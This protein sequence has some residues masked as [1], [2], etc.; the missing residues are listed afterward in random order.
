MDNERTELD[1]LQIENLQLRLASDVQDLIIAQVSQIF[2]KRGVADW[3]VDQTEQLKTQLAKIYIQLQCQLEMTQHDIMN[4]SEYLKV[5][6][7]ET[8]LWP[9]HTNVE[10]LL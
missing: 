9:G 10:S 2:M 7:S 8:E 5:N 4:L 3:S 1:V 6:E